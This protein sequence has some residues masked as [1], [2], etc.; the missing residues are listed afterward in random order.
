MMPQMGTLQS[1]AAP[2]EQNMPI[3]CC[4]DAVGSFSSTCGSFVIPHSACATHS[5]GTQQI[6][7]SPFFIQISHHET[8]TP[9][10]K[11]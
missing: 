3:P 6:A 4:N 5:M 8:V 9:P 2:A 7:F 1:R 11:V 10:P